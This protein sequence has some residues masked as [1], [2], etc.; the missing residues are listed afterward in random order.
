M[1]VKQLNA[2][3]VTESERCPDC[4]EKLLKI[5]GTFIK[6]V[7]CPNCKY[8]KLKEMEPKRSVPITS[9]K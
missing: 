9:M 6:W 5:E 7:T 1:A 2:K 8:K 4:R 3:V